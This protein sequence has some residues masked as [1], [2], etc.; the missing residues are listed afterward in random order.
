[1]GVVQ[2]LDLLILQGKGTRKGK[3][4]L[5]RELCL[6]A[7]FSD[8]I[9]QMHEG[10]ILGH[11]PPQHV[12][13][14]CRKGF[15]NSHPSK[16]KDDHLCPRE[17]VPSWGCGADPSTLATI[18]LDIGDKFICYLTSGT[19]VATHQRSPRTEHCCSIST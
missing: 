5:Q 16:A 8:H 9:T 13:V 10:L 15:L 1:M 18:Q 11:P 7:G 12:E 4:L 14:V 2:H 19:S 6:D 3:F 17:P